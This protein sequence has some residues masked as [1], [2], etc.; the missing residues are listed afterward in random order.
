MALQNG[1]V[2]SQLMIAL[3]D[4]DPGVPYLVVGRVT[5]G[6]DIV[7]NLKAGDKITG[8]TITERK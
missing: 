5:D 2:S 6:L 1:Q 8:V 4:T 3:D 7:R